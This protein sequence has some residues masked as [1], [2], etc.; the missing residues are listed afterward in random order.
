[1]Q[2][3]QLYQAQF[4]AHLRQPL[5]HAKPSHTQ[6]SGM[7]I[8]REI[9]F[10]NFHASVSACFP[11]LHSILGKRRFRQL[12]RTCFYSQTFNSPLFHEIPA[13]FVRFLQT[14]PAVESLP[15]YTSQL[16][17]Y[18]WLELAVARQVCT[19]PQTSAECLVTEASALAPLC[20]RLPCA[21]RLLHYDYP[22]H[23]L[24]RKQSRLPAESTYLLI[25][26]TP[27]YEVRFMQINAM[28]YQL[29][30]ALNTHPSSTLSHLQRLCT[31]FPHIPADAV[32]QFGLATLYQ[33]YQQQALVL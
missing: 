21:H 16:A 10:R 31:D 25:Y 8:Y 20:L 5:R 22:V 13:E 24:S 27:A 28:T 14:D 26:R 15:G 23:R 4:T 29:L 1:M 30:Q 17:H 32:I 2:D 3:F 19:E 11:V 9:V 7:A 6:A 12:V 18:E 33:L